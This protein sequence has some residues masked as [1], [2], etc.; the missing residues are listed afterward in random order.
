MNLQQIKNR[1]G[2]IGNSPRLNYALETA[3]KVAPT[4]ITVYIQGESGVGKESFSKIIHQLSNRKHGPF[5]AINCGAIPEGTINS[6]LFGHEKGAFTGAI[7]NRKGY[8]ET[9]NGGTIFLDEIGELPLETQS[10]L[11]RLLENGEFIKVGSSKVQTTDVRIITATNKDLFAETQNGK[12]REDLYYRLSTLPIKVPALRERVSDVYLLFRKFAFDL[13]EKYH[14]P[15]VELQPD[16]EELLL[17][18]SWPGNIRQLKNLTEQLAVLEQ[19]HHISAVTLKKY[20]PEQTRQL[21]ALTS[22]GAQSSSSDFSERDIFYKVLFDMR[23]EMSDLKKI[24]LEL[25]KKSGSKEEI[26]QGNEAI[27]QR[28]LSEAS[29]QENVSDEMTIHRTEEQLPVDDGHHYIIEPEDSVN[30][31]ENLSLEDKEEELIKKAL[32][33][34]NGKRKRAARDLGISERTLYRKIKQYELD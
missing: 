13:A 2:I 19:D 10:R 5:F 8:F 23:N 16:A 12:F 27:I 18:Y 33:R 9:V 7:D 34:N 17:K 11:L 3:V 22:G 25:L 4:D 28:V 6:E 1:F 21:P 29:T 24:V 32:L 15:E 31:E 20:L 26:L 30:L 14:S